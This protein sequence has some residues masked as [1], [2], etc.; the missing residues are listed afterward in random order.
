V[1]RRVL[2][3]IT[4]LPP[5][6]RLLVEVEAPDQLGRVGVLDGIATYVGARYS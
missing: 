6:R 3:R 2:G 5:H 1:E 4:P